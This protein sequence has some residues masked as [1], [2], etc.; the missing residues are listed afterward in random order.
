[1][2][3]TRS[4]PVQSL[5]EHV[6][7]PRAPWATPKVSRT[8]LVFLVTMLA[9]LAWTQRWLQ[10]DAYITFTYSR[11]LASGIGPVWNPGYIVEGYT[12]FLWMI[13]LA[14]AQRIGLEPP[15]ASE[16]LSLICFVISLCLVFRLGRLLFTQDAW[17]LLAVFLV[18][19]NYSFLKYATGGLETQLNVTLTLAALGL[20]AQTGSDGK[21]TAA[22]ALAVS[23]L[24]GLAIMT[25]P[26]S[27]LL[28]AV[29]LGFMGGQILMSGA[30]TRRRLQLTGLVVLPLLLVLL[31]WLVWKYHFYGH[32]LPNTFLIKLG[33]HRPKTIL[34]GL[35]YVAW[36]FVSFGWLFLIA[37]ILLR[38]R[39]R[40]ILMRNHAWYPLLSYTAIWLLYAIAIGGDIMEF[41][42]LVCIFP[43]VILA[44]IGGLRAT[45]ASWRVTMG[46]SVVL[47]C[48]SVL[49]GEFFAI[50]ERPRGIENIPELTDYA[51]WWCKLG[52]T[53]RA[54]L[55]AGSTVKIAVS[56]AGAIPYCSG[57]QAIDVLGLNDLWVARNGY[58]RQTC[59]VCLGHLRMATI[60]YLE[61]AGANL[62]FAHPQVLGGTAVP[63]DVFKSMFWGAPIGYERA[64]AAAQLLRIPVEPGRTAL[65]VYLIPN[66]DIDGLLA[67][68]VWSGEPLWS[69]GAAKNV[70]M[71]VSEH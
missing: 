65:A 55:G 22:R 61:S 18:G 37:F 49:H 23:I 44:M 64:P 28:A 2:D 46:W 56:P 35:A 29:A 42:Q 16:V 36:P 30:T 67:R 3:F 40:R 24:V 60:D 58:V 66:R 32:L 39:G 11:N 6:E 25:R 47:L 26:D 45:F 5:P 41:R 10:D 9:L 17:A 19:T 33:V 70:A 31:P 63:L 34:R 27:V 50:Y 4:Q 15:I 59:D 20:V 62:V 71:P 48:A 43:I 57:L 13:L 38:S 1:M 8:L 21:A 52:E 7:W 69:D 53:L 68:G 12:N 51:V 54:D 14:G